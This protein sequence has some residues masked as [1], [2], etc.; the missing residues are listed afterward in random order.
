MERQLNA[1]GLGFEIGNAAEVLDALIRHSGD[2]VKVIDLDGRVIKWNNACEE[3]YG[4][5]APEVT[6]HVLP[7]ILEGQRLKH[8][9]LVREACAAGVVSEHDIL[10][11]RADGTQFNMRVVWIPLVDSDGD[12]AG[13]L[14]IARDMLGDG[15]LERQRE[16]FTA[17][18]ARALTEPLSIIAN[19]AS[20]LQRSEVASDT[21]RRTRLSKTVADRSS[22]LT[23]L[24]EDV[25]LIFELEKGDLVLDREPANLAVLVG[26][27]VSQ[28]SRHAT[29]IT[30]D[31]DPSMPMVLVDVSRLNRAINVLIGKALKQAP[32]GSAVSVSVFQRGRDAAIE[33]RDQGQLADPSDVEHIFDRHYSGIEP[34]N[35]DDAG[36]GLY[37]VRSIA[38]AH[39]GRVAITTGNGVAITM[40]LP[41]SGK[42]A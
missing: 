12:V 18:I 8:V 5:T 19:A 3:V 1:E 40:L 42:G 9:F 22:A 30:V 10:S 34:R 7:F 6:G 23:G 37:L 27:A 36:T 15:R 29:R 25:R 2:C 35:A 33:V 38:Q 21:E 17:F 31:F 24:V 11:E 4:W 16:E 13:V 32:P 20:L 39:G 41:L 26:E 14:S 28:F